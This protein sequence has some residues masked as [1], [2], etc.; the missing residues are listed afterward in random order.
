MTRDTTNDNQV[1]VTLL[2]TPF[3]VP[4]LE[5]SWPLDQRLLADS[6][7]LTQAD[8]VITQAQ[9]PA[10][11]Q[12][13]ILKT[14]VLDISAI[15]SCQ[16]PLYL[17]RQVILL[18]EVDESLNQGVHL[19][20]LWDDQVA[21][22]Q[23]FRIGDTLVLFHPFVH[24]CDESEV[25]MQAILADYASL[26]RLGYYLEYGSATVLFAQPRQVAASLQMAPIAQSHWELERP[27]RQFKEIPSGWRTFSLYA[28]VRRIQVSH[29]LPLLAAFFSAYYDP[30]MNQSRDGTLARPPCNRFIVDKYSLVVKLEVYLASAS[31]QVLTIEVTG[32]MAK[33]ALRLFPGQSVFLDGLVAIDMASKAIQHYR[34]LPT[35]P[36]PPTCRAFAFPTQAYTKSPSSSL[37]ALCSDW[38]KIFGHQSLFRTRSK[39]TIVNTTLGLF[40]TELHRS[41]EMWTTT[42]APPLAIVE[43]TIGAGGWLIP[44]SKGWRLD[45]SCAKGL[46]TTYVH[47]ACFRPLKLMPRDPARAEL[48]KWQCLFCHEMFVGV[49]D[50]LHTYREVAVVLETG[51]SSVSPV[52]AVC[53]GDV[54]ETLLQCSSMDYMQLPLQEKRRTLARMMGQTFRLV[55]SRC[56]PRHVSMPPSLVSE[57]SLQTES[58]VLMHVR[59]DMV[60]PLNA[61]K[62]A[63]RLLAALKQ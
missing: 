9:A 3:L 30:K 50:T 42:A 62:A 16:T 27:Y 37:V 31:N 15:R 40:K 24:I 59:M 34:H 52:F 54:I 1:L 21:L 38:E 28:H 29:G 46:A 61:F 7:E 17:H 63:H 48:P 36:P 43:M 60:E 20:V 26:E 32:E 51:H 4:R 25:E 5:T 6:M 39:L 13:L 58:S 49:K 47:Q 35:N 2:P 45:V 14:K 41:I 11:M 12:Q 57:L 55:L 22:S 53:Q 33:K 44:S 10:V 56:E 8:Q 18:G 19:L 23:L